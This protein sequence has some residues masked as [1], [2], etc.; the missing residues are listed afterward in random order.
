M[1]IE[2]GTYID[3]FFKLPNVLILSVDGRNVHFII[4]C[5]HVRF[6]IHDDQGGADVLDMFAL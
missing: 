2:F 1:K 6:A 4:E 5:D 3:S